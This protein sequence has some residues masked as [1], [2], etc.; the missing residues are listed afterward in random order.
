MPADV[1]EGAKAAVGVARQEQRHAVVVVREHLARRRAR[2]HGRRSAAAAGTGARSRRRGSSRWS[3][4]RPGCA[5]R[6]R[7]SP[8]I[9]GGRP[10]SGRGC[11]RARKRCG[12]EAA[13]TEGGE[14]GERILCR[15]RPPR[16]SVMAPDEA[17]TPER[18]KG[19]S[20]SG[21]LLLIARRREAPRLFR[22]SGRAR[23][24]MGLD[25]LG[26][27]THRGN[28]GPQLRFGAAE[29]RGPVADLVLLTEGDQAAIG[30]A[31]RG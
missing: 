19:H 25:L 15:R 5:L 26:R 13:S 20:T 9:R 4:S 3:S 18:K 30:V 7:S 17:A 2:W 21:P 23:L 1:E 11:A 16:Q 10:G 22:R 27:I 14:T 31:R 29:L 6:A 8:A 24:Q 12:A 28:R